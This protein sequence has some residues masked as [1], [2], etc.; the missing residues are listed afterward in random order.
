[1][2]LPLNPVLS[3]LKSLTSASSAFNTGGTKYLDDMFFAVIFKWKGDSLFYILLKKLLIVF[4]DH[5]FL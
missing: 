4:S 3:P 2:L 1:M 5:V